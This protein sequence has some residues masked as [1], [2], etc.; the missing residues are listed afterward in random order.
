MKNL[1]YLFLAAG[2]CFCYSLS[3]ADPTPSASKPALRI[4]VVNSKKCVDESRFGKQEQANFEKMKGQME[5][6]LQEKEKTLEDIE[7]KLNDD[8]YMDSISEEAAAELKRKRRTIRQDGMQLQ[9]Q[10]LQALQQANYKI[11][12]KLTTIIAK[13]SAQVAQDPSNNLDMIV[14]DEAATYY[15]PQF[16]VSDKVIAKMNAMPDSELSQD[17]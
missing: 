6:V 1:V 5:S 3:A 12:Q 7:S 2:A 11:I 14:S 13:A 15:N 9:N 16:D 8:D 4:G 10:Y 17:K